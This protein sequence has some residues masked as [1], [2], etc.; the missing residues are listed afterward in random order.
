VGTE[1][2]PSGSQ[3]PSFSPNIELV[4][5]IRRMR[6]RLDEL[7]AVASR[8]EHV[9]GIEHKQALE[10][11]TEHLQQIGSALQ[12]HL[13]SVDTTH[14]DLRETT[15][16][17]LKAI[18]APLDPLLTRIEQGLEQR[19]VE[20]NTV[21]HRLDASTLVNSSLKDELS[22][23]AKASRLEEV[24]DNITVQLSALTTQ[25]SSI[26]AQLSSINA[27]LSSINESN[28]H[29]AT[30]THTQLEHHHAI[31]STTLQRI[32]QKTESIHQ[33]TIALSA[34]RSLPELKALTESIEKTI[35]DQS[36]IIKTKWTV[37]PIEGSIHARS[38]RE[39][40]LMYVSMIS[41]GLIIILILHQIGLLPTPL[42]GNSDQQNNLINTVKLACEKQEQTMRDL[43]MTLASATDANELKASL[44]GLKLQLALLQCKPICRCPEGK[45]PLPV[46]RDPSPPIATQPVI[47]PTVSPCPQVAPSVHCNCL[48]KEQT[49]G[50]STP[51]STPPK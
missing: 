9:A 32:E 3:E 30:S 39:M 45:P 37:G 51:A 22:K 17:E 46:K 2:P 21:I 16:T 42:W 41:V 11:L 4:D 27:Q 44:E 12:R 20:L 24:K 25:L 50:T 13:A 33:N 28:A 15:I 47:P 29:A 18:V 43:K 10:Q 6:K 36:D 40:L 31:N 1:Q 26:N 7:F 49:T 8:L 5:M 14:R 23:S 38:V 19:V 35:K 48:S 34:I